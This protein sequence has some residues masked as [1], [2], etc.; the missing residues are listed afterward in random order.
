MG[1]RQNFGCDV[2]REE[3]LIV[4]RIRQMKNRDKIEIGGGGDKAS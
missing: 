1:N 2:F 3:E 4:K